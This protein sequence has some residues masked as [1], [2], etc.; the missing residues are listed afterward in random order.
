M[1]FK[2][3]HSHIMTISTTSITSLTDLP[4]VVPVTIALSYWHDR[5]SWSGN[6][7]KSVILIVDVPM[8]S[9]ILTE[10]KASN[11][12]LTTIWKRLQLVTKKFIY[13]K[14]YCR[15]TYS[16]PVDS[17]LS[18]MMGS[19]SDWKTNYVVDCRMDYRMD[20]RTDYNWSQWALSVEVVDIKLDT[21]AY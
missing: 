10:T 16:F 11:I 15:Y 3:I 4:L 7:I 8:Y 13:W 5:D 21:M 14:K 19:L 1:K 6:P 2:T 17:R 9:I 18:S 12:I 20:Y